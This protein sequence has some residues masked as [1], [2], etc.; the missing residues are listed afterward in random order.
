MKTLQEI[1]EQYKRDESLD[2]RDLARLIQFVPDDELKN[3]GIKLKDG[4]VRSDQY[5]E[6]TRDN[7]LIQLEKDVN[8]GFEK[9]L[10]RRGIS[11]SIMHGVVSMWNWILQEGLENFYDYAHYGLPLFK[12][13]AIKYGFDNPIGDDNGDED[14][15][16]TYG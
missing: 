12:A 15:Y 13:T 5:V 7:V 9:A 8:F 10:N 6:M 4:C 16:S 14:K 2:G 11:S 3:F 1:K